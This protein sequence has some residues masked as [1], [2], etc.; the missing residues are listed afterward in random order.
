MF[1]CAPLAG[2]QGF[3]HRDGG[4]LGEKSSFRALPVCYSSFPS[5]GIRDAAM[6]M[7]STWQSCSAGT[8]GLWG[9]LCR[10]SSWTGWSFQLRAFPF[11]L[12]GLSS[13]L[14]S[15]RFLCPGWDGGLC[16]SQSRD[17]CSRRFGQRPWCVQEPQEVISVCWGEGI[18][19]GMLWPWVAQR[20]LAHL[21]LGWLPG[22]K[23]GF[24]RG[25]HCWMAVLGGVQMALYQTP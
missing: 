20:D 16:C 25:S 18:H 13:P 7:C 22:F 15:G 23:A 8:G 17:F 6:P 11:L 4:V 5:E 24:V 3:F 10:A 14:R 19:P 1:V 12:K 9:V 21:G 2:D